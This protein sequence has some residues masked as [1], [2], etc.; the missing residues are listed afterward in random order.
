[1]GVSGRY[2]VELWYA[3]EKDDVG[4]EIELRFNQS[5]VRTK[6]TRANPAPPRGAEH[7]RS[8]RSESYVKDFKPI[9]MGVLDLKKGRGE[10]TLHATSIPGREAM[11]FRLLMFRR[12]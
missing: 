5:V 10:L 8:P 12:L 9:K 1:V 4:S 7:D 11:E 3:C 6:I 2:E